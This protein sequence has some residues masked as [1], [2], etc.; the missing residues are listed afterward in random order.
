MLIP[1]RLVLCSG[2]PSAIFAICHYLTQRSKK[3]AVGRYAYH[4]IYTVANHM[5]L[6]LVPIDMDE[7]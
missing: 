4:G 5:G 1:G 2:A 6:Q 7:A 3:V